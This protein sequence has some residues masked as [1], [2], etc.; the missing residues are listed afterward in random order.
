MNLDREKKHIETIKR[1]QRNWD[2]SKTVPQEHIDHWLWIAQN[3]PAKQYEAYYD[4][5]YA[6][7]PEVLRD[8]GK[9]TWGFTRNFGEGPPS[10]A[11][12]PQMNA[13]FYM[14]FVS[15]F[16]DSNHNHN[17]DG[18]H[19]AIDYHGR[20]QNA[21]VS[22]GIAMGLVARSAAELGYQ[23]G[24]NKNHGGEPDQPDHWEKRMGILD[25]V[26]KGLLRIEYGLGIGFAQAGRAHSESDEHEIMIGA[27]NG[28]LPTLD[29]DPADSE[30]TP[31]KIVDSTG[32]DAVDP[33]GRRHLLPQADTVSYPSFS[34]LVPR[35]IRCV[36]IL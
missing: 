14:C 6:Q 3:S 35:E 31:V 15:K 1:C 22:I 25:E 16:P 33:Q 30:L 4:V 23:T 20:R 24:Y 36:E 17:N 27:A 34:E 9:H 12:N 8:L 18:T 29:P 32:R 11:R 2:Y 7:R 28:H 5:Y 26:N 10:C 19:R 13:N 21:L